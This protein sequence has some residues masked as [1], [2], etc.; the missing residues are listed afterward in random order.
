MFECGKC[1][2]STDHELINCPHR[3]TDGCPYAVKKG[4][5]RSGIRQQGWETTLIGTLFLLVWLMLPRLHLISG[6]SDQSLTLV[7]LQLGI[8]ALGVLL[9]V[10]LICAGV[11]IL[12]TK[13][14]FIF[15]ATEDDSNEL[16]VIYSFA[17]VSYRWESVRDLDF[18]SIESLTHSAKFDTLTEEARK[19]EFP[20]IA[21]EAEPVRGSKEAAEFQEGFRKFVARSLG[22]VVEDA[23]KRGLILLYTGNV[24]GRRVNELDETLFGA[25]VFMSQVSSGSGSEVLHPYLKCC[26]DLLGKWEEEVVPPSDEPMMSVH[27][28]F[29]SLTEELPIASQYQLMRDIL[30]SGTIPST[31][32]NGDD[33]LASSQRDSRVTLLSP[34][35]IQ[36]GLNRKSDSSWGQLGVKRG[37]LSGIIVFLFFF[38]FTLP[39]KILNWF[40]DWVKSSPVVHDLNGVLLRYW[41]MLPW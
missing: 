19:A 37:V 18:I 39:Y 15:P 12:G 2:R 16:L 17:N 6:S 9:G 7:T 23:A 33:V 5:Y 11:L 25:S 40:L 29:E 13:R 34:E 20:W 1:L 8:Y 22:A 30:K 10:F 14:T 35:E 32:S 36:S 24:F 27:T 41:E 31:V 21:G 28:L 3:A 26:L 38:R 4:G